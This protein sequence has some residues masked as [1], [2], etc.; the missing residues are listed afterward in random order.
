MLN[1]SYSPTTGQLDT[2]MS[3]QD[4]ATYT[5][6]GSMLTSVSGIGGNAAHLYYDY[7]NNFR[8]SSQEL[9]V[10]NPNAQDF[11]ATAS[12]GYDADGLL[13]TIWY[14]APNYHNYYMVINYDSQGRINGTGFPYD[15]PEFTT[16][17][18]YDSLGMLSDYET[19]YNNSTIFQTSYERD[20][21]GRITTL[22]EV[23]QGQTSVKQYAYDIAG[24]LWQVWRNDTLVSTYSYDPNGNRIAHLTS[25]KTDSGT[26]DAQDR[27][28]TYGTAQYIYTKNGELQKKITGN[29][30]TSYIYDYLGNLVTVR[31]SSGDRI[32]YIIDGHNRRIG[33]K[34]NGNLVK[35][36]VYSGQLTP[37]AEL[38]SSG[39]VTAQFIGNMM[40]KNGTVYQLITDHLG[41]IRLVID[42]SSGAIAQ[43]LDYDEF[44]N[45]TQNTNP[46]FQSFAYAG[47][48]YDA[49]TKLV[50]FGA[51]DYDASV[52]RWTC[53][54]P[55]GFGGNQANFYC[56]VGND[57]INWIDPSGL[58]NAVRAGTVSRVGWENPNNHAQG[59][60]YR[61]YITT[62][63]GSVDIYAHMDPSTTPCE[64]T[65]V[66]AGD[67][68]GDY[69]TPT[70]GHSSGPHLHYERRDAQGHSV[71][72]GNVEPIPGGT[73]TTPYGQVDRMHPHGHNGIDFVNP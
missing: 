69:A 39:N 67:Y 18:N 11:D 24:R 72:P 70:N 60:G 37:S 59:F 6:D 36:W 34:L 55:I 53:K 35:R 16:S 10:Q 3:P 57:P 54:D 21:L 41:S 71:N 43:Q 26:Y 25:T 58:I 61:I 29:D 45:V 49:Q 65:Q 5:Y 8:L 19:D 4:T 56:Y 42:K 27:M 31:F 51:R 2:L 63:D 32:D 15:D 44:G 1:F 47:G 48:L 33:K 14:S 68:V 46:D 40:Y 22:T 64:G 30:T 13:N 50:R 12:Y 7:D 62:D 52:G 20:S 9:W 66:Q 73:V 17:Q 38:D 28:L 23:N